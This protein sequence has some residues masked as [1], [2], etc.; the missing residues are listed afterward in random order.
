MS[1]VETRWIVLGRGRMGQLLV[2]L[3]RKL[4]VE[5]RAWSRTDGPIEHIGPIG[6]D[7]ALFVA[8]ADD[9][10]ASV[11]SALAPIAHAARYVVHCSG[12]VPSSALRDAGIESPVG[13]VHPLLAIADPALA[14]SA[15]SDA[16]WTVEGDAA[17]V[18]WARG[19]LAKLDIVPTVID[20]DQKA[21]Y[22]AAAV[23]SAGLVVGLAD[24]AFELARHA[25]ID[26]A[27]ARR[28]LLPLARST[29]E[30]L[31]Q[32]STTE[33]LTGPIARRDEA[34]VA[35]HREAMGRQASPSALQVYDSLTDRCVELRDRG[36]T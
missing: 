19:W 26:G 18:S 1:D 14:V 3:A 17:A 2:L 12:S 16:A 15:V 4:S 8:V 6:P 11:A 35:A 5:V 23:A 22:H 27:D 32:M 20:G 9:A 10:I 30:N 29:L 7:T 24:V 25:G 31:Q 33:A 21:L 28:I 13:C 36:T 34:T